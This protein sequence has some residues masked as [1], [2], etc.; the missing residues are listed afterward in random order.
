MEP[1]QHW[2]HTQKQLLNF[3]DEILNGKINPG[4]ANYVSPAPPPLP[5]HEFSPAPPTPSKGACRNFEKHHPSITIGKGSVSVID[6]NSASDALFELSGHVYGLSEA[7]SKIEV[8]DIPL[9]G[10]PTAIAIDTPMHM[11][12]VTDADSDSV[13]VINGYSDEIAAGV[14]FN[15]NPA[16]SG[17]ITCNNTAV[18]TNSY[19]YVDTG[20]NCTAQPNKD[21]EFN[22]W[23]W[24]PLANR[25]SSISLD[26]S[27]NLT[28]NR[29]GIFTANFNL[30]HQ[31]T[32]EELAA[33][34]SIISSQ[35]SIITGLISAAV[36][37]NGALLV[38]PGWRRARNQRTHLREC[39][40]MIDND[41][42]KSHKDTIEDKI[43][44]YY[45]DGKLSEDHRQLLKDKISEYYGSVKGSESGS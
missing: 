34:Y 9:G 20:T 17:R 15:V 45:V 2:L 21:F 10:N 38:V 6:G 8:K 36:A 41:A 44:G 28:V 5:A 30:P 11:I 1:T 24:S 32:A 33:Q 14:I 16:N 18:P 42:D 13:S 3:C 26:S 19:V 29:Y 23:A 25:N 37:V 4:E 31:L 40:K 35:Y 39:I 12:Y 7:H 27:G 43:F 22:T